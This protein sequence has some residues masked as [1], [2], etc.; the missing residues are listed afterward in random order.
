M[1][2]APN[3]GGMCSIPDQVTKI[4]HAARHSQKEKKQKRLRFNVRPSIYARKNPEPEE[5][6]KQSFSN[7]AQ[8]VEFL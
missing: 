6:E 8:E 5:Q 2:K 3:A 4:L 7:A 1:V